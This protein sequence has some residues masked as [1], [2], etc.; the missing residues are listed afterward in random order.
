MGDGAGF[1]TSPQLGGLPSWGL[2]CQHFPLLEDFF[3]I[4]AWLFTRER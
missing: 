2:F 1:A 4:V 3:L